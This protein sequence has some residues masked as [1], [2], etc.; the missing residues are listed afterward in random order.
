MNRERG[1]TLVEVL[2]AMVVTVASVA[3]LAQ[4][5]S[6]GARAS[7]VS[8]KTMRAALLAQRVITDFELGVLDLSSNQAGGFDDE[9]DFTY[10]TQSDVPTPPGTTSD[11]IL[12]TTGLTQLTV[13]IKWDDRGRARTYSVVRLMR[14]RP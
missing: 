3:I 11:G 1:F 7:L 8:E 12:Y 10:E 6:T 13:N 2:V 4:G 9:P 5:F 14:A